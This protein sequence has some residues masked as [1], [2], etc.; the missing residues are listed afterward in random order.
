MT[1]DALEQKKK[2]REHLLCHAQEKNA[3]CCMINWER[4]THTM[5]LHYFH[6]SVNVEVIR[7]LDV[8]LIIACPVVQT[9]LSSSSPP[10]PS[11]FSYPDWFCLL[12]CGSRRRRRQ[13]RNDW[14][15]V[16][17]SC[18]LSLGIGRLSKPPSSVRDEKRKRLV[19]RLIEG[20][21]SLMHGERER[22][23]WGENRVFIYVHQGRGDDCVNLDCLF[24]VQIRTQW[25]RRI[26]E[27]F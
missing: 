6:T 1:F 3:R 11:S 5:W 13:R 19:L 25:T 24:L 7:D 14:N 20:N 9:S 2:K 23:G 16:I 26:R 27:K 22:V 18:K 4:W 15:G 12:C 21:R 10:P 8:L 17:S